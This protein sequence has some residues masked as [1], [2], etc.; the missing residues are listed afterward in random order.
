LP[1]APCNC[2]PFVYRLFS[3]ASHCPFVLHPPSFPPFLLDPFTAR[4]RRLF[5]TF[6]LLSS[7]YTT[8]FTV[9]LLPSSRC[10]ISSA[11]PSARCQHPFTRC[12][13][14]PPT[15]R[16]PPP[17]YLSLSLLSTL[18]PSLLLSVSDLL[19]RS[20]QALFVSGLREYGKPFRGRSSIV[21]V[22]LS[23]RHSQPLKALSSR[24]LF[25]SLSLSELREYGKPFRGRPPSSSP[26]SSRSA[27]ARETVS[28][29]ACRSRVRTDPADFPGTRDG[30]LPW[31]PGS[32]QSR[33][34]LRDRL[35]ANTVSVNLFDGHT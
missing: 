10:S 22:C 6:A 2:S 34:R 35:E 8:T 24:D 15:R 14:S 33:T 23:W 13:P 19:K 27:R 18:S 5:Y 16:L 25:N 31:L 28:G 12:L 20:L 11:L 21:S 4:R 9:C 7:L 30:A 29:N 17:F 32:V 3:H 26:R 1:S